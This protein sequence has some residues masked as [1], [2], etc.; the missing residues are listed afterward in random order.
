MIRVLAVTLL[1]AIAGCSDPFD[2]PYRVSKTRLLAVAADLPYAHPGD[3]VSLRALATDPAGRPLTFAWALCVNPPAATVA[4]C[5]AT[6]DR[7]TV[8]IEAA[9]SEHSIVVPD[10]AVTTGSM[11]GVVVVACPGTL[12]LGASFECTAGGRALRLEE[13]EVGMKRVVIRSRDRNENPVAASIT[14]DGEDWPEA[15][16]PEVDPCDPGDTFD[17]C[18]GATRHRI[19][20]TPTTIESGVD[21]FAVAFTEQVLVQYYATEGTFDSPVRTAASPGTEWVAR[22][23]AAGTVV[24]VYLVVRDDRGGVSFTTRRVRVR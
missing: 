22:R 24:E 6:F 23:R 14:F 3:T 20:V 2:P 19:T 10:V 13:F 11:L 7:A 12:T 17:D 5:L 4:G 16:I 8:V 15:R 1:A 9:R 18:P 21:E